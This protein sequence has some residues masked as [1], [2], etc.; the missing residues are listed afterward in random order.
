M[1]TDETIDFV[2]LVL[3][4][5]FVLVIIFHPNCEAICWIGER[6]GLIMLMIKSVATA[7]QADGDEVPYSEENK[8]NEEGV[9]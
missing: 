3:K 1:T 9:W 7:K 4:D 2:Y 8:D 6:R 5:V